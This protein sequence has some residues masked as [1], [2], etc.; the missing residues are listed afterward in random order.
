MTVDMYLQAVRRH[1]ENADRCVDGEKKGLERKFAQ[2]FL[3]RLREDCARMTDAELRV[4]HPEVHYL[5]TH[6]LPHAP[7]SYSTTRVPI[8]KLG[9][10]GS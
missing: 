6:G 8:G 1:L 4:A 7:R 10:A 2:M 5:V 9:R 3:E